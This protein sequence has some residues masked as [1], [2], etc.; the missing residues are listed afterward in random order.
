MID[1]WSVGRYD[2]R[3]T[4][5]DFWGLTLREFDALCK[6]KRQEDRTNEYYAALISCVVANAHRNPKKKTAPYQPKDFMTD[7][8]RGRIM[9]ADQMK[10][11]VEQITRMSGGKINGR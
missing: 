4:E 6:R 8:K 9:T 1:L 11:K 7:E 2:L 10:R 5:Q 3:L